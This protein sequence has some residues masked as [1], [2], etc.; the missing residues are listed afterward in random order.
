MAS[1]VALQELDVGRAGFGG[2]ALGQ[3]QHLIGHVEAEGSAGGPDAP[4]GEEDVDP[5]ARAQVEHALALVQLRDG[6]RVAAAERSEHGR[7][8]QL[9][10]LEG[11]VQRRRRCRPR[12]PQQ[13]LAFPVAS[14]WQR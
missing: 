1:I 13:A 11:G 5:A 14:T 8:G 4:G 2:I 7:I 3:G 10:A 12:A 6:G 9:G